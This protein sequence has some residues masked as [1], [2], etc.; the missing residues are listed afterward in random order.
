M[1]T[2]KIIVPVVFTYALFLIASCN[3]PSEKVEKAQENVTEAKEEL[4]KAENDY[5]SDMNRFRIETD[6][7]IAENQKRID[8]LKQ[9]A[10]MDK[11]EI[12]EKNQKK[13]AELEQ[14]N[15]DLKRRIDEYKGEG[16]DKWQSFKREFKR[17]MEE[18]GQAI[19]DIGTNNVNYK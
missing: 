19:R 11:K 17:D 6:S 5:V 2:K 7:S 9:K 16:N 13:I 4:N 10:E 3:S 18:L 15:K 12:K 14:R 1:K 8:E